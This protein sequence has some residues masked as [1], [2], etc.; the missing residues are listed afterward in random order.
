L[1]ASRDGFSPALK[2]RYDY[3]NGKLFGD[4]IIAAMQVMEI[5]KGPND[6]LAES[7]SGMTT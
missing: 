7:F 5:E 4:R 6:D 2:V 1:K 3:D